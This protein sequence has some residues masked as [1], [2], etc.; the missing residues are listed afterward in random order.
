[1]IL[2]CI[3]AEAFYGVDDLGAILYLVKD[4]QRL[5]RQDLLAAG[6]HQVLQKTVNVFGCFKELLDSPFSSKLK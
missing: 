5:F 1:M 3:L 4:D 6:Q 2:W